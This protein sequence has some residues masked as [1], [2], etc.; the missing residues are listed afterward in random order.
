[1]PKFSA[2]KNG[3]YQSGVFHV[4]ETCADTWP[5]YIKRQSPENLSSMFDMP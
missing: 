5:E 2:N 4:H 3:Q 1:M